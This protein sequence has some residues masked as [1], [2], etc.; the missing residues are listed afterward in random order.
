MTSYRTMLAAFLL[1]LGGLQAAPPAWVTNQGADASTFPGT[2]YLTGFGLSSTP[3]D[4]ARQRRIR[5]T[6][7][8]EQLG[9]TYGYIN[10]LRTGVR[11]TECIGQQFAEACAHFLGVPPIVIKLLAGRILVSDF[12]WTH[13]GEAG[14]VERAYRRMLTDPVARQLV[15]ANGEELSAAAKRSLVMLYAETSSQD[16]LGI[17]NLSWVMQYL[18]RLALIHEA[19]Q[20]D[21]IPDREDY[22]A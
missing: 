8:A 12:A 4:E 22:A 2:A 7:M 11:G 16:I 9:V 13:E 21:V 19:H 1:A 6:E 15:P 14:M 3:G 20:G 10:Q 17:R 5:L 18:Q